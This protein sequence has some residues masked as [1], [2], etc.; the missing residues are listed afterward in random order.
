M[1]IRAVDAVGVEVTF[2]TEIHEWLNFA[3]KFESMKVSET[4]FYFWKEG[5]QIKHRSFEVSVKRCGQYTTEFLK[6]ELF[7]CE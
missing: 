2:L 3:I 6:I 1:W 5:A 4:M 7:C